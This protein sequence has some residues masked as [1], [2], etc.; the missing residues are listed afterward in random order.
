[1]TDSRMVGT[2]RIFSGR[3]INLDIDRVRLK[4]G[5]EVDLEII[6]HPGAAAVVPLL[7]N[8][9]SDPRVVLIRQFRHAA[10]QTLWEIPAGVLEKGEQPRDCA[11]RELEEETG[12]R[13]GKIEHLSTIF[14]TPGF[15]DEKIHLFLATDIVMG[16]ATPEDDEEIETVIKPLAEVLEMVSD[17]TI[18]DS[19]TISA[20]L[21]TRDR[22]RL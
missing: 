6:R 3:V 17:G 2:R 16:T 5:Q 18:N 8:A 10:G 13:A 4:T 15:T 7:G 14:T 20:L 22:L 1:M 12:A 19:K 11:L 9:G 21:L